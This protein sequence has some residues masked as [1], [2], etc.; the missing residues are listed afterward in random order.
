MEKQMIIYGTRILS[1]IIF[2]L[3]IP[4]DQKTRLEITLLRNPPEIITS[5]ITC[6][7]P[8]YQAHGRKVYLYSDRIFGKSENKQPWCYEVKDILRFF[9]IGGESTIYYQLD[10]GI[11]VC[12]LGFWFIHLLLPFYLTLEHKFNFIHSASIEVDK[13]TILFIAPSMG[14]KSTM[15]NFFIN[16]GHRLTSDD[17]VATLLKEDCFMAHSSHP[18]HRPYRN[19]EDL[20]NYASSYQTSCNPIHAFYELHKNHSDS[21][22]TIKEVNGVDKFNTIFP[23]FLYTFPFLKEYRLQYL[24]KALHIVNMFRVQVP[25]NLEHLE[26]VHDSIC[27][28]LKELA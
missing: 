19:F 3:N 28:H 23:N 15:T 6:G 1:D 8:L 4:N 2:P 22:V 27:K 17:K 14:G 7:F 13:K 24:S 9:W 18:Y 5:A 12:L 26:V 21:N 11:D 25:W 16:Q 20:G 10:P